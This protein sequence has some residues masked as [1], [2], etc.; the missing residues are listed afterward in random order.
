MLWFFFLIA[1][2][3]D[4]HYLMETLSSENFVDMC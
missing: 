3:G 1:T 2:S 4:V